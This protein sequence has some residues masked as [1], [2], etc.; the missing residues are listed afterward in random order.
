VRGLAAVLRKE[1]VQ[2]L[3][4]KG[5][6]RFALALPA[7]QLVLFGLI[8]TNVQHVPTAVMDWSR[9]EES[10]ALVR[11]FV[12]TSYFDVVAYASSRAELYEMIVAGTA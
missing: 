2:M 7:F 10:R 12:N 8:D 9:T 4:D 6:L 11:G 5:T 1:W 3:R